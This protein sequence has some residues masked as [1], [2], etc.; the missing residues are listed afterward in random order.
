MVL[1]ASV[2]KTSVLGLFLS[3]L[4]A[5][6]LP[7]SMIWLK[8]DP[9]LGLVSAIA[10]A[11][12]EPAEIATAVVAAT[13]PLREKSFMKLLLSVKAD[14]NVNHISFLSDKKPPKVIGILYA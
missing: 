10:G 6:V 1:F 3:V 13:R 2:L 8:E 7:A 11:E 14:N 12:R 4:L 9:S 5:P